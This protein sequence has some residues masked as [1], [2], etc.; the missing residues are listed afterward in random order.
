M[1][2]PIGNFPGLSGAVSSGP[3]QFGSA[4]SYQAGP[5]GSPKS[6]AFTYSGGAVPASNAA[7]PGT[8][9]GM[10]VWLTIGAAATL[11]LI[12]RSLPN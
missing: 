2:M 7:H 5:G 12:R 11:F 9:M 3:M 1:G 8:A 10:G 4:E 6:A